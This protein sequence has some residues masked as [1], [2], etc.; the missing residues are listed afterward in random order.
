MAELAKIKQERAEEKAKLVSRANLFRFP[1]VDAFPS[2]RSLYACYSCMLIVRKQ[3]TQ[4]L[5]NETV[6]QKSQRET[7]YSISK[8]H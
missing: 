1:H 5:V 6:K 3:R 2:P 8:R 7:H 4:H